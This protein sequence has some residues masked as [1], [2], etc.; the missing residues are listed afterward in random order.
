M[1][2]PWPPPRFLR[3]DALAELPTAD[4]IP[5]VL[6][7]LHTSCT[8]ADQPRLPTAASNARL[9]AALAKSARANRVLHEDRCD[10]DPDHPLLAPYASVL[11]LV[12]TRVLRVLWLHCDPLASP[13][14]LLRSVAARLGH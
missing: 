5:L 12:H 13:L 14:E 9:V 4:G 1:P 11:T 6:H 3:A 2:A 10:D 8:Y 7:V